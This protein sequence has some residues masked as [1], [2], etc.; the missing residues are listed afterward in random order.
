M[1]SLVKNFDHIMDM[2][3]ATQGNTAETNIMQKNG[4]NYSVGLNLSMTKSTGIR[5]YHFDRKTYAD[6]ESGATIM[7]QPS[8]FVNGRKSYLKFDIQVQDGVTPS[9]EYNFGSY[10]S[11]FNVIR[12]IYVT[13]HGVEM[14]RVRNVNLL[15]RKQ[16]SFKYD[17]EVLGRDKQP[18]GY[19]NLTPASAD[20]D[21]PNGLTTEDNTSFCLNLSELAGIFDTDQL[22]PPQIVSGL[23]LQIDWESA[24]TGLVLKTGGAAAASL[25]FNIVNPQIV[26][27]EH[28]LEDSVARQ[29]NMLASSDKGIE[30]AYVNHDQGR[31]STSGTSLVIDNRKVVSKATSEMIVPRLTA[32][33]TNATKDSFKSEGSGISS[34]QHRHGSNFIPTFPIQGTTEQYMVSQDA[35]KSDCHGSGSIPLSRFRDYEGLAAISLERTHAMGLSGVPVNS[36]R[37]LYSE[38]TFDNAADR[39]SDVFLK[40]IRIARVYLDRISIVE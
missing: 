3:S 22:L 14:E 6:G 36:N 8:N 27:Y 17:Q 18:W 30:I 12:N 1:N 26:L 5:S 29:I 38:F 11:A 16:H 7:L 15:K 24:V 20:G 37:T 40:Y 39:S 19:R 13:K 28:Q 23:E 34:I 10:G 9:D 21:H 33:L 35:L 32:N 31:V 25:N 4:L 2:I